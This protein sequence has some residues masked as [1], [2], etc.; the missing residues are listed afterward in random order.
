M[1]AF[2]ATE[3]GM[4]SDN[5]KSRLSADT[6]NM[7]AEDRDAKRIMDAAIHNASQGVKVAV[8][9]LEAE[10]A[11]RK[12]QLTA[13]LDKLKIEQLDR[14]GA[15]R[16]LAA[17]AKFMGEVRA[18]YEKI[19]SDRIAMLPPGTDQATVQKLRDEMNAAIIISLK[20]LRDRAK[21]IESR[22]TGTYGDS[23]GKFQQGSMTVSP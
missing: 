14:T 23:A 19:Y 9:N 4:L 7:E 11:D 12:M 18:K 3:I 10:T 13:E 2:N 5:A 16:N 17:V 15:E 20:D 6:A 8:A 1:Q 22:I 21:Q